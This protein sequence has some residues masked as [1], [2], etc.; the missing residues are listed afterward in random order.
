MQVAPVAGGMR[1]TGNWTFTDSGPAIDIPAHI[2]EIYDYLM[3]SSKENQ[4]SIA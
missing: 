4:S 2:G 1:E 3:V